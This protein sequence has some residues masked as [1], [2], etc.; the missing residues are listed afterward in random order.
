[1]DDKER[2]D[3]ERPSIVDKLTDPETGRPEAHASVPLQGSMLNAID[4]E[5]SEGNRCDPN[6]ADARLDVNI[7]ETF[8]ASDPASITQPGRSDKD[9]PPGGKFD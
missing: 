3:G 4:M 7:D 6:D 5:D 8:P 9:P 1:M 2:R